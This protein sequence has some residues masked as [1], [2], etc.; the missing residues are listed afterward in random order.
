MG[1]PGVGLLSGAGPV[2]AAS[3]ADVLLAV[4]VL[5]AL[6]A[7]CAWIVGADDKIG[8]CEA[9]AEV[10]IEQA[11]H[12]SVDSR[13]AVAQHRQG[14]RACRIRATHKQ[15]CFVSQQ[16]QAIAAVQQ[17]PDLRFWNT[18]RIRCRRRARGCGRDFRR[19]ECQRRINCIRDRTSDCMCDRICDRRLLLI[20]ACYSVG[21]SAWGPRCCQR[22]DRHR[23]R[24]ALSRCL[25]CRGRRHGRSNQRRRHF[26]GAAGVNGGSSGRGRV[27]GGGVSFVLFG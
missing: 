8:L 6:A 10:A 7:A 25:C 5:A 1:A 18:G 14:M 19:R 26:G 13:S 21:S 15:E 20:E 22:C 23:R 2:D 24:R 17:Q 12:G 16:P 27:G 3:A 11:G 4:A 9:A